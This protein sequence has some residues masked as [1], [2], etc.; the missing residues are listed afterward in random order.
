MHLP[1]LSN[2][3]VNLV[4]LLQACGVLLLS[5]IVEAWGKSWDPDL[6]AGQDVM[7]LW[8]RQGIH[9]QYGTLPE[10]KVQF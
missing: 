1:E 10:H 9:E 3:H 7:Y 2:G 8:S 4:N 5:F 6:V